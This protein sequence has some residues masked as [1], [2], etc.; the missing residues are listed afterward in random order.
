MEAVPN[1]IKEQFAP[2]LEDTNRY[3]PPC[4]RV[5]YVGLRAMAADIDR[6]RDRL[7]R[8]RAGVEAAR[9]AR[10]AALPADKNPPLPFRRSGE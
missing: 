5:R 4:L 8:I 6:I 1:H 9:T 2:Y 10:P 7:D 3:I